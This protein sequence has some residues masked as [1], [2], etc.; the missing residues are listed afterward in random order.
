MGGEVSK[1][2]TSNYILKDEV[3]RTLQKKLLVYSGVPKKMIKHMRVKV[4]EC[5]GESLYM[6]TTIYD[7]DSMEFLGGSKPV[8]LFA[9]GY[10]ASGAVYF[11]IYKRLMERFCVVT[12][13]HMGFGASSRP[14]KNYDEETITPQQNVD[15]FVNYL[16]A[17]RKEF[18]KKI[19][20]E[21][22]GF[23]LMGHSFG[24]YISGNYCLKY[25]QHVK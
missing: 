16:E 14:L 9:H 12:I 2:S 7:Y 21:F 18:S 5:D 10:I 24:G 13:D 20:A 3:L 1:Q 17:W 11:G 25:G 19:K 4:D 8:L 23:Y 15:Y 6:W 22:T